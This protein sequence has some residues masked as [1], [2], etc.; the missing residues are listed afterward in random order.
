LEA[1][2]A[3]VFAG[4]LDRGH[5][6]LA[7]A[8][9]AATAA[10]PP[11]PKD[12][13]LVGLAVRVTEDMADAAP[14]LCEALTAFREDSGDDPEVNRWLWLACRVA[15]DLFEY[16]TW[17]TLAHRA[18]RLAR[19][20]GTLSVL[21][22]AASYLAGVHMHAGEY[23]AAA[24][25][26]E[27]SSAITAATDAAP[28]IAT[29]PMLAAYRGSEADALAQVESSRANAADRGQDTALSMIDCAHAVLLNALGR[30]DE[31]FA[32]ATRACDHDDVSLFAISLVEMV[33]AAVRSNHPD[34]AA[35]AM[36]RLSRRMQASGSDWALG[37]EARSRALLADDDA[38]APLYEE[39]VQRLTAA[40]LAPH[41]ARAQ[42]VHGEWLR[43]THQR[44]RA[45]EQLRRAHETFVTIGAGAFAERARLELLATGE[46]VR[47]PGVAPTESLTAQEARIAKLAR[48]GLTNP[49]IGSRL[50]LSPH[51][52]EWHLRKVYA[53]LGVTSR[54]HLRDALS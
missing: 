14:A 43:R 42:L 34:A 50:F 38:A 27:E 10:Q 33:E 46:A 6:V 40:G 9:D 28:L 12:L 37:L 31:A 22:I 13:L 1:L 4:R 51:T 24:M 23:D 15:A 36:E 5:D 19:T 45:R 16:D 7:T 25:L 35:A 30:Y 48:D 44:A 20:D 47:Q 54:R 29:L 8:R 26:M 3:A 39:A 32:S 52:V 53:K 11:S 17:A 41:R 2:G 18:V 21:P 49:E